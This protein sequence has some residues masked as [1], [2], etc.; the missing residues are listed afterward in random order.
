MLE[1]FSVFDR[2]CDGLISNDELGSVLYA[3]GQ[4]PTFHELNSL[5]RGVDTRSETLNK[6][7]I[8]LLLD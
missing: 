3:M 4:R 7:G 5:I 8:T 1:A 2:D 6:D